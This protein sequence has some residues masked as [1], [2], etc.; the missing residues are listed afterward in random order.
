MW[1]YERRPVPGGSLHRS[2]SAADGLT[3]GQLARLTGVSAKAIRYYESAGLLPRPKRAANGYRRYGPADVNRL[4]VLQSMRR[5]GV[6]L[7]SATDLLAGSSDARC[8]EVQREL[9]TLVDERVATLDQEIAE[10]QALRT[11]V[12][13]YQRALASCSAD[14]RMAFAE[15]SD[16]RCL[17]LPQEPVSQVA[18]Q[19]A[20]GEHHCV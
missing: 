10:L 20:C 1:A 3:I 17:A 2:A 4:R 5:L 7:S 16:L 18:S 11:L 13:G 14:D 8:A 12:E 19:E 15:C 9:L 6:P